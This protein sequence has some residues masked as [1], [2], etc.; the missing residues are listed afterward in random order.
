MPQQQQSYSSNQSPYAVDGSPTEW[1]PSPGSPDPEIQAGAYTENRPS[2]EQVSQK[3]PLPD[4]T[5]EDSIAPRAP[6]EA[7]RLGP[8]KIK[9]SDGSV[10]SWEPSQTSTGGF[11]NTTYTSNR[12]KRLEQQRERQEARIRELHGA[13]TE[14]EL[15]ESAMSTGDR[16]KPLWQ[17]DAEQSGRRSP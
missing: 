11:D 8:R 2:F 17:Q 6:T 5:F 9:N 3:I 10:S 13:R 14:R 12:N 7:K 15:I 16:Q 4:G 1:Q